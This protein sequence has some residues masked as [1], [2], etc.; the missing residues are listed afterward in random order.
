[1][2]KL[3][4]AVCD[5]YGRLFELEN[6]NYQSFKAVFGDKNEADLLAKN[7]SEMDLIVVPIY[8]KDARR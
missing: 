6:E 3:F 7:N 8:I 2:S 4:H 5:R 1:M